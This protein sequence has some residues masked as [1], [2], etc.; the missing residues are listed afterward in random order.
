M[1]LIYIL[2]H[3]AT[4]LTGNYYVKMVLQHNEF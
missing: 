2:D 4:I 1:T 3:F